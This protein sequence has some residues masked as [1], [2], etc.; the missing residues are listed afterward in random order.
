[1]KLFKVGIDR[2]LDRHLVR[3]GEFQT[4]HQTKLLKKSHVRFSHMP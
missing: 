2:S 3:Q 1:M 4:G